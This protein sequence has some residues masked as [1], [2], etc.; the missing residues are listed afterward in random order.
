MLVDSE[1]GEYRLGRRGSVAVTAPQDF[2]VVRKE[3]RRS[4]L[5][6]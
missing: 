1:H 4:I 2:E 6:L 3:A 5:V